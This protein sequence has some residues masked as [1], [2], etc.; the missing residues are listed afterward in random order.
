ME[1]IINV[2]LTFI[3]V[4]CWNEPLQTLAVEEDGEVGHDV[5]G[6]GRGR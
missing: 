5:C 3:D 1:V 4:Y 6:N 2:R